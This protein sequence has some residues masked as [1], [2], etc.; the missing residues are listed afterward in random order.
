MATKTKNA[1][2][3]VSVTHGSEKPPEVI[4]A[5]GIV[6]TSD[7][8]GQNMMADG[9]V[10]AENNVTKTT[11]VTEDEM[12]TTTVTR[13]RCP[14]VPALMDVT[15]DACTLA[16]S[17]CEQ[18]VRAMVIE[19]FTK[20]GHGFGTMELR[21]RDAFAAAMA[22][23]ENICPTPEYCLTSTLAVTTAAANCSTG[24]GIK[25]WPEYKLLHP[26]VT[27]VG[28]PEQSQHPKSSIVID[29][30]SNTST[31]LT[32]ET[33]VETQTTTTTTTTVTPVKDGDQHPTTTVYTVETKPS[34]MAAVV[35]LDTSARTRGVVVQKTINTNLTKP[36]ITVAAVNTFVDCDKRPETITAPDS[37][38]TT[39][40]PD[41]TTGVFVT[42]TPPVISTDR[43][44]PIVVEHPTSIA[45]HEPR[46]FVERGRPLLRPTF[47]RRRPFSTLVD[48]S[49]MA[50]LQT[51]AENKA[52]HTYISDHPE[53]LDEEDEEVNEDGDSWDC[54]FGD[55]SCLPPVSR[56][57]DFL[58]DQVP[59]KT[60]INTNDHSSSD[61][62]EDGS[63]LARNRKRLIEEIARQQ[64][65]R[66]QL[67]RE[68][69]RRLREHRERP[70][71]T[72]EEYY[73][74]FLRLQYG[75]KNATPGP[76]KLLHRPLNG[77]R[78]NGIVSW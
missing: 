10:T 21:R 8:V 22:F 30:K 67:E 71:V 31:V 70:P 55:S 18:F 33:V 35:V 58:I 53:E 59:S 43:P 52:D 23:D 78:C 1:T 62:D 77:G 32:V 57:N 29:G 34:S 48:T 56:L 66:D 50:A 7:I 47:H 37:M 27:T 12:R 4:D 11:T 73:Q 38:D 69:E 54:F 65:H 44:T 45:D 13:T 2:P 3:T 51:T 61:D 9:D 76:P 16:V 49:V 68:M 60:P 75:S 28:V 42:K 24:D 14:I 17:A 15:M 41:S 20:A 25:D 19:R 39:E 64:H 36:K 46:F 74:K 5:K 6:T 63:S 40:I 72:Q 26:L